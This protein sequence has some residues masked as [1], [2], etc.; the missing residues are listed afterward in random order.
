[1]PMRTQ[2]RSTTR[3]R[4]SRPA[5]RYRL[6]VLVVAPAS[7]KRRLSA[8][9]QADGFGISA[10]T[11]PEP[12]D[13]VV[14][15][16]NSPKKDAAAVA[17][18]RAR[19][20]SAPLLVAVSEATPAD[21]RRLLVDGVAGVVFQD[22]AEHA[23]APTLRAV[24][25]GQ[26]AY[27]GELMP[28]NLR[29]TLSKREKQVLGMV[30]LGFSNAEIAAKLYVSESTVKSHLSSAFARLGVRSRKDAAALILDPDAGF[31]TG[32]LAIT[33]SA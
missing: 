31:G 15:G 9:L 14:L 22:Q 13:A 11:G 19:S 33:D 16:I 23:L 25:S 18:A 32:I 5:A 7:L 24:L 27:P 10:V 1:M 17:R 21:A 6:L 12:A 28:S 30:V 20:G 4:V 8:I 29:R 3:G 26:V 2:T